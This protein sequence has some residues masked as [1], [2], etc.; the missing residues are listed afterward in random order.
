LSQFGPVPLQI[1]D[2]AHVP[3][4][5]GASGVTPDDTTAWAG[6]RHRHYGYWCLLVAFIRGPLL[7]HVIVF[8]LCQTILL[9]M[10]LSRTIEVQL[11]WCYHP[12]PFSNICIP[13]T[14]LNT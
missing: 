3:L 1:L 14:P 4:C 11:C 9:L 8:T 13:K 7:G 2:T 12:P 10:L 5:L 6:T